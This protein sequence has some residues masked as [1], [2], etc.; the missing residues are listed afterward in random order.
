ML[1]SFLLP[2]TQQQIRNL[3]EWRV[4][5]KNDRPRLA[6]GKKFAQIHSI[7][8]VNVN[9]MASQ[10]T[11]VALLKNLGLTPNEARVYLSTIKLGEAGISEVAKT[12]SVNRSNAYA[13]VQG[14]V[15]HGLI[16]QVIT[17]STK[18]VRATP[19]ESLE[20]LAKA[21]Q[22]EATKLRWKIADLIPTL[23]G[24]LGGGAEQPRFLSFEGPDTL[25]HLLRR[26]NK[27]AQPGSEMLE[28]CTMSE[29]SSK[30]SE[31]FSQERVALGCTKRLLCTDHKEHRVLLPNDRKELRETRFLTDEQFIGIEHC[32]ICIYGDEVL[33]YWE[34]PHP[35]GVIIQSTRISNLMRFLF[36]FAWEQT[37]SP[38]EIPH[39]TKSRP[40]RDQQ[41]R[42]TR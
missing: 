26:S 4:E 5:R 35:H 32:N 8:Y 3:N 21:R 7:I 2:L 20:A 38:T 41:A 42:R 25:M 22:K 6:I 10:R 37:P 19:V 39:A 12:A 29:A 9:D 1:T 40:R 17:P 18:R 33:L 24:L 28:I 36:N 14:L 11:I 27:I 23:L 13:A 16:E 15:H 34:S 31:W 30:N